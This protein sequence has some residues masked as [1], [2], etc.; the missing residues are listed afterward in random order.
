MNVIPST[1]G[2]QYRSTETFRSPDNDCMETALLPDSNRKPSKFLTTRERQLAV[3]VAEGRQNKEI[4]YTLGLSEGTVKVY[5]SHLFSKLGFHNRAELAAWA[6]A[7]RM[8]GV[9]WLSLL[10]NPAGIRP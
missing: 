10:S 9:S 3:L 2:R 4:A 1:D 6:T 8:A 7:Q 5:M